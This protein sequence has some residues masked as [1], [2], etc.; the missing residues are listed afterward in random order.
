MKLLHKILKGASLTTALF[1]F[2]AC[3]GTPDWLHDMSAE[4]KVVTAEDGSPLEGIAIKSRVEPEDNLDWILSGYTDESGVA[5]VYF[6]Y[7]DYGTPQFRFESESGEYVI[8]D[9]I[10]T[11]FDHSILVKLEKAAVEE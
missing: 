6:G 5:N 8:K 4:F 7:S 1:I 2:Q 11:N 10:I 9:T 3:Y